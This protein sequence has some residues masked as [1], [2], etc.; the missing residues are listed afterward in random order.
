MQCLSDCLSV[1]PYMHPKTRTSMQG[2]PSQASQHKKRFFQVS[3]D[4][5]TLR[6]AWDKYVLLYYLTEL[7]T[8]DSAREV[9]EGLAWQIC[10]SRD[11]PPPH[12]LPPPL[13]NSIST[14]R[15]SNTCDACSR[16]CLWPDIRTLCSKILCGWVICGQTAKEGGGGS[17]ACSLSRRFVTL[18]EKGTLF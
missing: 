9:R 16:G 3:A 17:F 18:P 12:F 15:L 4:G 5:S 1:C 6:W 13:S 7:Q 2:K 14:R 10:S 8:N 11:S